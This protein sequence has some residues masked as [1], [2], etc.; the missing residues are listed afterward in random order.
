MFRVDQP[1]HTQGLFDVHP[2]GTGER[3]RAGAT[4]TRLNVS[5]RGQ[6]LPPGLGQRGTWSPLPRLEFVP[7]SLSAF[8]HFKIFLCFPP[9]QIKLV[10]LTGLAPRQLFIQA[11]AWPYFL[12]PGTCPQPP[13][14]RQRCNNSTVLTWTH[15]P[16]IYKE[17]KPGGRGEGTC[18]RAFKGY[19]R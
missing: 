19:Q 18:D 13:C 17:Q 6:N 5:V 11:R 7:I 3:L 2:N 10:L 4:F 9:K 8:Q 1:A 15:L 16:L 12:S 14:L